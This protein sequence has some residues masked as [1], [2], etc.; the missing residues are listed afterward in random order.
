MSDYVA[1]L[2]R[3][4]ARALEMGGPEKIARQ[5]ERGRLTARERIDAPVDPGS[6]VELGLLVHS[7]V[8]EAE[9]KTP[10]DGKV[11]GVARIDGGR[12]SP[13]SCAARASPGV[14]PAGSTCTTSF[15]R[16]TRAPP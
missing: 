2:E 4:R 9:A 14:R 5:H 16:A 6:F 10:A 11:C 8:P 12:S 1:E 13:R 7:D 3:R 15:A